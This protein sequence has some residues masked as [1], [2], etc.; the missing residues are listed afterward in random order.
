LVRSAVEKAM[1]RPR[2]DVAA[3]AAGRGATVGM[4]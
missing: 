2:R 4:R 3:L 1:A